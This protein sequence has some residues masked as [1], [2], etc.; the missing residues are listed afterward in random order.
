VARI[1]VYGVLVLEIA[2]TS[3]ASHDVFVALM[4]PWGAA[5]AT[6]LNSVQNL[7]L[8]ISVAGGLSKPF[9]SLN[10]PVPA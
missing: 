1:V 8:S 7:W 4:S 2:Q 5:D 10:S 6:K 3:V 9:P